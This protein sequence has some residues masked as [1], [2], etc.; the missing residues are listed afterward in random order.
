MEADQ[1]NTVT[2]RYNQVFS[3]RSYWNYLRWMNTGTT[4]AYLG[5]TDQPIC[6][7]QPSNL[8]IEIHPYVLYNNNKYLD[9]SLIHGYLFKHQQSHSVICLERQVMITSVRVTCNQAEP[10]SGFLSKTNVVCYC[11]AKWAMFQKN[12]V[13]ER[14]SSE[15]RISFCYLLGYQIDYWQANVLSYV[16]LLPVIY[17][18]LLH[19]HQFHTYFSHFFI[20]VDWVNSWKRFHP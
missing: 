13:T 17:D 6:D 7:L 2:E 1:Y 3:S 15:F 18:L 8:Q 9:R 4:R 20:T 12:L 10:F 16:V 14:Q 19:L 5:I 11:C